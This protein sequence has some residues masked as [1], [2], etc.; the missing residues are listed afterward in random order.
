MTRLLPAIAL[1]ATLLLP[2]A[3]TAAD[4]RFA[5]LS[6]PGIVAIVRHAHAPGTGDSAKCMPDD[7]TTQRNLDERGR[8]QAQEIEAAIR[9]VGVTVDR[10]LTNQSCRCHNITRLLDLGPVEDLP[11]LN[12]FL[13]NPA[14]V[15]R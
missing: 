3:Q 5:R 2:P 14:R 10:L 9:A 1:I 4:T 7:C 15:D 12:S 13:R 8:K 6:Q 11:A